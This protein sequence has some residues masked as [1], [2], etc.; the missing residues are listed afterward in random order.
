M[1]FIRD[2]RDIIRTGGNGI[3]CHACVSRH[4][5]ALQIINLSEYS[6]GEV[7]RVKVRKHEKAF[8]CVSPDRL[9]SGI[10]AVVPQIGC[11][12]L[13]IQSAERTAQSFLQTV[14]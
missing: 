12:G 14:T 9:S 11:I 13:K 1:A 6:V 5:N 10:R 7:K 4:Q 2:L 8:C 3:R